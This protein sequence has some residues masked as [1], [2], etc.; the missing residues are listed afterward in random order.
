MRREI[1]PHFGSE[2]PGDDL[3]YES[4]DG[5]VLPIPSVVF[6]AQEKDEKPAFDHELYSLRLDNELDGDLKPNPAGSVDI[7]FVAP[8]EQE[9]QPDRRAVEVEQDDDVEKLSSS[10]RQERLRMLKNEFGFYPQNNLEFNRMMGILGNFD[11]KYPALNHL[12]HIYT[13]QRS[14]H[15]KKQLASTGLESSVAI[16]AGAKEDKSLTP[17]EAATRTLRSVVREMTEYAR[18]ARALGFFVKEIR[19]YVKSQEPQNFTRFKNIN[20]IDFLREEPGPS[21]AMIDGLAKRVE[22]GKYV[23]GEGE[24]SLSKRN[25]INNDKNKRARVANAL[26]NLTATSIVKLS[27]TAIEEQAARRAFWIERLREAT[28]HMHVRGQAYEALREL[29]AAE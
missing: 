20:G 13:H 21:R 8:P 16:P 22:T 1:Q 2:I 24:D 9:I 23:E 27:N 29:G 5:D 10:D 6:S 14:V 7:Q 19:D 3:N 25:I 11:D 18:D 26:D 15:A 12:D 4:V 28:K 17:H